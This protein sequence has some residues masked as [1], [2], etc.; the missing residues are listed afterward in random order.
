MR[1]LALLRVFETVN[2]ASVHHLACRLCL[3]L[4]FGRTPSPIA[5]NLTNDERRS[6][7]PTG[8]RI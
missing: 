6:S 7:P 3:P 5:N 1:D 8:T 2:A 4:S